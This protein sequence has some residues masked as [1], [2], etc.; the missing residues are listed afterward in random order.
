MPAPAPMFAPQQ[1]PAP[2]AAID[3]FAA[4]PMFASSGAPL[5]ANDAGPELEVLP[6]AE[7]RRRGRAG[8]WVLAFVL[9]ASTAVCAFA[10][11]RRLE[12]SPPPTVTKPSTKT[13]KPPKVDDTDETSATSESSETKASSSSSTTASASASASGKASPSASIA[14]SASASAVPSASTAT[15]ASISPPAPNATIAADTTALSTTAGG[16]GHRVFVDGRVVGEG[17]GPLQV[18]CGSHEVKVGSLGTPKTLDLPCG[19]A[20][21]ITP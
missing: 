12:T 21:T 19:A 6:V 20:I 13:K 9:F 18:P 10:L 17:P 1:Q 16:V 14:A 11:V 5:Y 2:P 3:P 7:P 15:S 8:L 4:S